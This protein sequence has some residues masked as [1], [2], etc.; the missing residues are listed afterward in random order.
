MHELPVCLAHRGPAATYHSGILLL[1]LLLLLPST[2]SRVQLPV[3]FQ[4]LVSVQF[5][6]HPAPVAFALQ[7][8][9]HTLP[10]TVVLAQ[11]ASGNPALLGA[12]VSAV[13]CQ[14]ISWCCRT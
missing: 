3:T 9:V 14:C 6:V 1:L 2:N 13:G 7:L 11:V 8:A 10:F 12:S 5:A 4:V